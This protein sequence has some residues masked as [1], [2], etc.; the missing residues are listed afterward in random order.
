LKSISSSALLFCLYSLVI[1]AAH[2]LID[3]ACHV[4]GLLGGFVS[5]A[6]L[7][8]PFNPEARAVPQ[9]M[10]LLLAI[11]VVVLPLAGLAQPLIA[12]TSANSASLRF[13]RD[14]ETFI[15]AEAEIV[16][17]QT[18]ILTFPP[19]ARMNRLEIARRLREEVLE[20]WRAAS[21]PLLQGNTLPQDD[22]KPARLQA[23]LRDYLR[24]RD[25]A[26]ELRALAL[27]SGEITD[28]ARAVQAEKQLGKTLN[29]LNWLSNQP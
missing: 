3:N 2:P 22:S 10:K 5:G 1:G 12:G 14:M 4:G 25:S 27:E 9:P 15:S 24:A 7:A 21:R 26:V 6:I 18:E 23:A 20:P 29:A 17:R 13:T 11:L 28:E 8:R 16:R 19:N